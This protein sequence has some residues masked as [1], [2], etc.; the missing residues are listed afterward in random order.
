MRSVNSLFTTCPEENEVEDK[1][2]MLVCCYKVGKSH[3]QLEKQPNHHNCNIYQN[4][5][6]YKELAVPGNVFVEQE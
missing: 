4:K 5:I 2:D 6:H 1:A 3:A